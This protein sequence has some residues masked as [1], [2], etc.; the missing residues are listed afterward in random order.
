MPASETSNETLHVTLQTPSKRAKSNMEIYAYTLRRNITIDV[1]KKKG[2]GT[3]QRRNRITS[4]GKLE[5]K[6]QLTHATPARTRLDS[7]FGTHA[8]TNMEAYIATLHCNITLQHYIRCKEKKGRGQTQRLH[9]LPDHL[10]QASDSLVYLLLRGITE[11]KPH[12][13]LALAVAVEG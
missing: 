3:R 4:T 6:R 5:Q 2:G 1:K 12:R 10:G 9:V 11:V 13:V 7:F 8:C